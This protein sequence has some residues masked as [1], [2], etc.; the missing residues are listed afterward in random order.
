MDIQEQ[1]AL[2]VHNSIFTRKAI[3]LKRINNFPY[4]FKVIYDDGYIKY[5]YECGSYTEQI[6]RKL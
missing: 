3:E 6:S 5:D 2:L 4:R 1:N